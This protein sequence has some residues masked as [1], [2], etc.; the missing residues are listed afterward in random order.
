MLTVDIEDPV[1]VKQAIEK[2]MKTKVPLRCYVD[3]CVHMFIRLDWC[4]MKQVHNKTVLSVG[5]RVAISFIRTDVQLINVNIH[6]SKLE[7]N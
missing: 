2:I 6:N 7:I 5:N 1:A 3:V 4:L